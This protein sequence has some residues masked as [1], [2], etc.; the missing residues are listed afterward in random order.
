MAVTLKMFLQWLLCTSQTVQTTNMHLVLVWEHYFRL[1]WFTELISLG[2]VS[3]KEN[4]TLSIFPHPVGM[5]MEQIKINKSHIDNSQDC[6]QNL[7]GHPNF[8][9]LTLWEIWS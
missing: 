6:Y 3:L 8:P 7:N 5:F 9:S 4:G 2:H 1:S